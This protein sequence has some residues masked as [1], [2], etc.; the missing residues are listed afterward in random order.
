VVGVVVAGATAAVGAMVGVAVVAGVVVVVGVV[1]V[2]VVVAVG[3]G[4][5]GVIRWSA[6]RTLAPRSR[7]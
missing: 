7:T 3:A 6:R 1:L 4:A 5:G 2:G